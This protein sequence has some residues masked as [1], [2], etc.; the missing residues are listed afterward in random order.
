MTND[1]ESK[2][3]RTVLDNIP[4]LVI[5]S[6][7][8]GIIQFTNRQAFGHDREELVGKSIYDFMPDEFT[9][10]F[11]ENISSVIKNHSVGQFIFSEESPKHGKEWIRL[12]IGPVV[13]DDRVVALIFTSKN[14]TEQY[15]AEKRLSEN[16]AKLR[17]LLN[18][19][20]E[21]IMLVDEHGTIIEW[22]QSQSDIFGISRED[23]IG[24]KAW[25]IQYSLTP[26]DKQTPEQYA[27]L[28]D[29]MKRYFEIGEAS[30][31]RRVLESKFISKDGIKGIIQQYSAPIITSKGYLLCSFIHDITEKR[32]KE[33][34]HEQTQKRYRALFEQNNDA[35]FIIDLEGNYL[36]VNYRAA[37]MLGYGVPELIGMSYRD[38]V[39]EIEQD[40]SIE[41]LK[42]INEE[43]MFPLYEKTFRRKDGKE[44]RVEIN[45]SLVRDEHGN[46]IHIQSIVR[47]ITERKKA[48]EEIKK[49]ERR[50]REVTENSLQG[51]QIMQ[52][53]RIVYANPAFAK[54]MGISREKIY[55]LTPDQRWELIHEADRESMKDRYR[56]YTETD[57]LVKKSRFRIVQ[58]S[59]E[60]RWV[61]GTVD[62]I[63]FDGKPAM[64]R[65]VI[66]ITEQV[67]AE[68]QLRDERDK[69][70][71]Y[72]SLAGTVFL[73]LNTEGNIALLNPKGCD[74]L[75]V[76]AE[77]AIG[78]SWFEFIPH[79]HRD[80]VKLVFDRLMNGEITNLENKE[81]PVLRSDGKQRIISW[82]TTV[83]RSDDDE[84]IGI[85]SSGEDITEKKTAAEQLEAAH[86]M[87]TLYMDIMGHD[88]RN[89]L[90]AMQISSD[91]LND[92]V[93]SEKAQHL[94]QQITESIGR[95]D[96]LIK[97]ISTTADLLST[98]LSEFYLCKSITMCIDEF[99]KTN[100]NIE[101]ALDCSTSEARVYADKYLVTA[102]M[103]LLRNA[104]QFAS[105]SRPKIWIKLKEEYNG[106]TITIADNGS[107]ISDRKKKSLFDV[108]RR[109][110]GVGL[111][112]AKQIVE[113][114][115]GSIQ[116]EDRIENKPSAGAMFKL[117][118][119]KL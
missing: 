3:H 7:I 35:V 38:V 31:L 54:I 40:D 26:P 12:R 103:N 48:E 67:K 17:A 66:D 42:T 102:I 25:D 91:L 6:D 46:P 14:I 95:C 30:W 16:E 57:N 69:L 63:D 51:I 43:I 100:E 89:Y 19:S 2:F 45:S 116:V 90:Q 4:T 107:G 39:T 37:E 65:T 29:T 8:D 64:Q 85:L 33:L 44:I 74:V 73:T 83:L 101:V 109:F 32:R 97:T 53:N 10:D 88:I 79:Q 55:T 49:S 21:G 105:K 24:Q 114:Y 81:R 86:K 75:G 68:T 41:R 113:K 23:A 36:D 99:Q 56:K 5:A 80:D 96:R 34:L 61:E 70:Q 62:I 78:E 87:A 15:I 20:P 72:L 82:H 77:D 58:P 92:T 18:E 52:G 84:I 71:K 27:K 1:T 112:Q 106:Y 28:K 93:H 98:S 110:G 47:D 111:H 59:G 117:W 11:M 9:E 118:F 50:Y 119:P 108:E 22:N 104:Q 76:S 13:S 94:T 115:G 60:V